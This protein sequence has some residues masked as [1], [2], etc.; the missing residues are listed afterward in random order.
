MTLSLLLIILIPLFLIPVFMLPSNKLTLY[1]FC[2]TIGTGPALVLSL[3]DI[4]IPAIKL[5]EVIGSFF[6]PMWSFLS[7]KPTLNTQEI[8]HL[9][10]FLTMGFM[11]LILYLISF[12]VINSFYIGVNPDIRK[13]STI[14]QQIFSVVLFFTFTYGTLFI[15]LVETREIL[16]LRDG[17]L[18]W[19][20]QLIYQ[21]K[22]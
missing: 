4:F 16:P 5:G 10:F 11:Y 3:L 21:I 20:F 19:L 13:V 9:S 22:A 8:Y 18:G 14:F 7:A 12:F 2:A 15:F 6:L 1:T 17:F